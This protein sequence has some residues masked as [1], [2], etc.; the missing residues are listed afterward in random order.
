MRVFVAQTIPEQQIKKFKYA[1]VA[2]N[3]FCNALI[4]NGVFDFAISITP[5][6]YQNK[7][8]RE[9]GVFYISD[10]LHFR[11]LSIVYRNLACVVRVI[12]R[13]KSNRTTIWFYNL[14][15]SNFLAFLVLRFFYDVYLIQADIALSDKTRAI[16][17]W[18][19]TLSKGTIFL[20]ERTFLQSKSE[21]KHWLPGIVAKSDVDFGKDEDEKVNNKDF[22]FSGTLNDF[23]GIEMALHVFSELPELNLYVSGRGSKVDI[24]MEFQSKFSNIKYLDFLTPSDYKQLLSRFTYCLSFRDPG[25]VGN[26]ENFPSKILEYVYFDKMVITTMFYN[27]G[28]IKLFVVPFEKES[29]KEYLN[30]IVENK[31]KVFNQI[32]ANRISL[33]NNYSVENWIRSI[34][35][36][37]EA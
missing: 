16:F 35:S 9:H 12:S 34:K 5:T 18:M 30:N 31:N 11:L 19:S 21:V 20:S 22:L 32:K 3:N 17:S 6:F 4:G 37:E 24:V 23:N 29:I 7:S 8:E 1:S 33:M 27:L 28:E 14:T 36:L 26:L 2:G 25:I 13:N 10:R 15:T